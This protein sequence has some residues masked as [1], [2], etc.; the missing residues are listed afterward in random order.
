MQI[1]M[2]GFG[3]KSTVAG[4]KC[5]FFTV[6]ASS[7][8]VA[9]EQICLLFRQGFA[10]VDLG[11]LLVGVGEISLSLHMSVVDHVAQV[12]APGQWVIASSCG[13]LSEFVGIGPDGHLGVALVIYMGYVIPEAAAGIGENISSNTD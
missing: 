12:V 2:F 5:F 7:C 13:G 8:I 3:V 9:N 6:E 1:S 11:G 10:E 4:N